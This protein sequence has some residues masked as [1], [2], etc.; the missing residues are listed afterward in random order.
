[1][2]VYG[3]VIASF[4]ILALIRRYRRSVVKVWLVSVSKVRLLLLLSAPLTQPWWSGSNVTARF[5]RYSPNSIQCP[6]WCRCST[7][8]RLAGFRGKRDTMTLFHRAG[9]KAAFFALSALSLTGCASDANIY[10]LGLFGQ[11]VVGN[12]AYVT[13]SNVWN[14]MDALPLADGH[15][16]KYGRS[17]RFNKMEQQRAVFDC[18]KSQ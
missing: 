8:G 2:R 3:L 16:R 18:V 1:M 7:S 11:R 15:C 14:E 6:C 12:D 9:A 10:P 17:A 5:C 13:I 4:N